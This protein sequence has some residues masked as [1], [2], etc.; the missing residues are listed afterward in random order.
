[1][2]SHVDFPAA[3]CRTR[4]AENSHHLKHE[5][6]WPWSSFSNVYLV[7]PG[8]ISQTAV[9]ASACDV[10]GTPAGNLVPY[11]TA[12]SALLGAAPGAENDY[13]LFRA[14]I[15]TICIISCLLQ[16]Q[17]EHSVGQGIAKSWVHVA[18]CQTRCHEESSCGAFV[19]IH[20]MLRFQE[21][22]IGLDVAKAR[23]GHALLAQTA[24]LR[25]WQRTA[26]RGSVCYCRDDGCDTFSP[27]VHRS[28]LSVPL[29]EGPWRE[30]S[31]WHW[32]W[33][34]VVVSEGTFGFIV[35]WR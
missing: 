34:W 12:L 9:L 1:M 18:A 20:S 27:K 31:C 24:W 2:I 5:F 26:P 23:R 35:R 33:H 16:I 3:Q 17:S 19:A 13:Q 7:N 32:H 6:R 11:Y 10:V 29:V 30:E 15:I 14:A 28:P 21:A 4:H 25:R 8:C 22:R